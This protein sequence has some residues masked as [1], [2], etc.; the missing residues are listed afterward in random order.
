VANE[1]SLAYKFTSECRDF[2][3]INLDLCDAVTAMSA[4][5]RNLYFEALMKL[6]QLQVKG[7]TR[8]WILFLTTRVIRDQL[9]GGTKRKLFSC[10][11]QNI[12]QH[13]AFKTRT[14][15]ALGLEESAILR[16]IANQ[17]P[18][19]HSSLGPDFRIIA[20]EVALAG[21]DGQHPEARGS[22]PQELQLRVQL[23]EP[24]MLSPRVQVRA[25]HR[26]A[27]R[28]IR[29]DTGGRG[30]SSRSLGNWNWPLS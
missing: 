12:N 18:L 10:V 7:R 15:E 2:D 8:P 16:E 11:V 1:R 13:K 25:H 26:P 23:D 17:E 28:P 30:R 9:D 21:D 14:R 20:R 4:E 3:V 6:A 5:E 22:S 24:D 19:G 27:G 29:S